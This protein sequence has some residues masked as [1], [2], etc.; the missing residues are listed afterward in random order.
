MET[1]Q[2]QKLLEY[3]IWT[4]ENSEPWLKSLDET[5]VAVVSGVLSAEEIQTGKDKWWDWAEGLESGLSRHNQKTCL[6]KNWPAH[7]NGYN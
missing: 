2:E 3:P 5:G 1:K 7:K 4:V 6:I